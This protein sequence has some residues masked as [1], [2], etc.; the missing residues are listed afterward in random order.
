MTFSIPKTKY[1][2]CSGIELMLEMSHKKY[3]RLETITV[4]IEI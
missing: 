1:S 4:Y 3:F 2:E